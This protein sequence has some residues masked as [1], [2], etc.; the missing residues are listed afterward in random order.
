MFDMLKTII[1]DVLGIK[2]APVQPLYYT[3]VVTGDPVAA[4]RHNKDSKPIGYPFVDATGVV[5]GD[6]F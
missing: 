1:L 5:G 2:P 6:F 4:A 3:P